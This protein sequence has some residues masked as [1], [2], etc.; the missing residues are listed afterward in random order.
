[1][2]KISFKNKYGL[3]LRGFVVEPK[4][5]DTA[6]IFLHG[7]P[8]HCQGFTGTRVMKTI[9]KTN[10]LLLMFDFSHGGKSD[11]RF[12]DKVMSKEVDDIKCAIDFLEKKYD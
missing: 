1:M 3:T 6:I 7:F 4:K 10:Y 5:I 12:E 11:G 2:K 8:G 9:S